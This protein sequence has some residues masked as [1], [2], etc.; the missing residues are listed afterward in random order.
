MLTRLAAAVL[1]LVLAAAGARAREVTRLSAR[2]LL[3]VSGGLVSTASGVVLV[4][5]AALV[6]AGLVAVLA[7][8]ARRRDDDLVPISERPGTWWQRALALLAALALAGL[9][10]AAVLAAVRAGRA[11]QHAGQ[12]AAP[13]LPALPHLPGS[14]PPPGGV[15]AI[16]FLVA[17]A[18]GLIAVAAVCRWLRRPR[19]AAAELTGPP[20]GAPSSLA[21]A[22]AAGSSALAAGATARDAIISCYAAMEHSLAAAGAPRRAAD[23][24]EELLRRAVGAGVLRTP[25]AGRLTTLFR[26][27]RFSP[28]PLGPAQRDA[29]QTA[30]DEI[31]RDLAGER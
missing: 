9:V 2:G 25:A 31:A 15:S 16:A 21:A 13:A 30:L 26:E 17:A 14:T 6:L 20:Q 1:L 18:A 29:A 22:V 11:G 28:H 23:T 5:A 4:A 3:G 19:Q 12:P 27:A 7:R 24:P 10:I 8:R